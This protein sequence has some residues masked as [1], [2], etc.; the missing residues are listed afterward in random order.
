MSLISQSTAQWTSDGY[1]YMSLAETN[2]IPP[3]DMPLSIYT[4]WYEIAETFGNPMYD[5]EN[6]SFLVYKNQNDVTIVP[7]CQMETEWDQYNGYNALLTPINGVL[8]P[9]GCAAVAV[10]QIMK[11]HQWPNT[12]SWDL[13][14]NL[15]PSSA[16]AQF[17]KDLGNS[18]HTNYYVNISIADNLIVDSVLNSTYNYTSHYE[19]NN[20]ANISASLRNGCPVYMAGWVQGTQIGH[21]WVCSEEKKIVVDECYILMIVSQNQPL[22]FIVGGRHAINNGIYTYYY[23]NWGRRGQYN[24]WFI[25]GNVNTSL[26]NFNSNR[27]NIICSPNRN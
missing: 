20:Y 12:I 13:M 14:P 11:Y 8:P 27:H 24:G 9:V 15:T 21:A 10:G 19:A 18:I 16:T 22:E 4:Q 7:S 2:G 26:G 23:M 3:W 25:Q 17:L 1:E 6:Y 5:Y